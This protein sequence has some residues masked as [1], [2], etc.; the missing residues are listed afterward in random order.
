MIFINC[1]ISSAHHTPDTISTPGTYPFRIMPQVLFS[2]HGYPPV[3]A[4]S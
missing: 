1:V 2:P 3:C 4:Y